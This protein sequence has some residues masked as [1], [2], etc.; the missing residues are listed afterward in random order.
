VLIP[1]KAVICNLLSLTATFGALVWV[2]QDG[3]L[4]GLFGDF[5]V[6]GELEM[7]TPILMLC[8]A[9]GLS[10]DYEVFLVSRIQEAH[11]AGH[12]DEQAVAEGLQR[13]GRLVTSAALLLIVVLAANVISELTILKMLGLGLALAILVDATIVRGLLVPA[14]M[15]LA[16]PANW[17][18]PQP[19]RQLHARFG[20]AEAPAEPD[21]PP[22]PP[23]PHPPRPRTYVP[24]H[25]HS[26]SGGARTAE[27]GQ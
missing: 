12:S 2:F 1:V 17:W 21:Q 20:L 19:L 22:V 3:H 26:P 5:Q 14:V 16:G 6:T 4:A 15:R 7:F 9:F 10:M 13:T 27:G 18:A 8:I 23:R 25:A 24:L 11:L